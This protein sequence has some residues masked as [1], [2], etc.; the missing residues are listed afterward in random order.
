LSEQVLESEQQAA[1]HK[2]SRCLFREA[3]ARDNHEASARAIAKRVIV[4]CKPQF[5]AMLRA[6]EQGLNRRDAEGFDKAMRRQ[7]L[8]IATMEVVAAR[9]H[10]LRQRSA[11]NE[12]HGE[13]V[14]ASTHTV[15][16]H[17]AVKVSNPPQVPPQ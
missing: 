6:E 12:A 5:E 8:N 9:Q 4:P 2:V 7:E 16:H 17:R 14:K 3:V 11:R 1:A 13:K 15:H 10:S